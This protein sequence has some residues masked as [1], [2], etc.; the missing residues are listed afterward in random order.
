MFKPGDLVTREDIPYIT[1]VRV[2]SID[3]TE[4]KLGAIDNDWTSVEGWNIYYA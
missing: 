1:I 2:V 3:G 4:M